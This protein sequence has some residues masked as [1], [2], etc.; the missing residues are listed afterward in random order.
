M[1][2]FMKAMLAKSLQDRYG[3][4]NVTL[5]KGDEVKVLRGS[6]KGKQ[7]KVTVVDRG[8]SRIQINGLQRSKKGGEKLD[9]W[10]NPSN[11]LIIAPDTS[12]SRRF[13]KNAGKEAAQAKS[14]KNEETLSTKQKEK[15]NA[16]KKK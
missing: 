10:F 11:V 5:R 15:E 12:D 6:F 1:K 8:A 4:Q 9:T 13:K 16:P 3:L 7:G 14:S 2:S